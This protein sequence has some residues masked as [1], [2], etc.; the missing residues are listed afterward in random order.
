M[1]N[2]F[3]I[4]K[5]QWTLPDFLS[6]DD[7]TGF[8]PFLAGGEEDYLTF[9]ITRDKI[10]TKTVAYEMLEGDIGYIQVEQ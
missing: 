8:V 1:N 9:T 2:T 6:E 4:R 3:E 7:S 10:E 5:I